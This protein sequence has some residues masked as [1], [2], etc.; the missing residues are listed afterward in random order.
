MYK[1]SF[2]DGRQ[3]M[4]IA[5]PDKKT[6]PATGPQ[7]PGGEPAARVAVAGATGYAGQELVRLLARHPAV[8]LTAAMSSGATSAPRPLPALARIWDQAV[9]PLDLDQLSSSA[10]VVFLALPETASAEVAPQAARAGD[11]RHRPLRRLP[12]PRRGGPPALVP[13]HRDAAA[14]NRLRAPRARRRGHPRRAA[15]VVPRLLSYRRAA[16]A[17]AARRRS[18]HRGARHRRREV[19]HLRRRQGAERPHA[20]LREPRQRRRLRCLLAPAQRRDRAGAAARGDVRSPSRPTRPRH[21][22]D[23]LRLAEERD[24]RGAGGEGARGRLSRRGVRAADRRRA[25][26]DQ[27]RGPHQLLRYRLEGGRGAQPARADRG[28]R[29][30]GE[31]RGW[32]GGAEPQ[33]RSRP[34]RTDGPAVTR[35]TRRRV[36]K[37]P[38][39]TRQPQKDPADTRRA[40][41]RQDPAIV[42]KLGGELLEQPDDLARIATG[43]A[44]LAQRTSL[45]VVHGGG[46]EIDSALATAGIA[47]QQVDG[48]RVTDARTLDVVVAVLAGAI[49]TRLVAALR[50][51][52]AR[53]VGLTGADASVATMKRSQPIATVAGPKVDLGLVGSPINNGS[54]ELLTDLLARR[55]VPVVACIGATRDGELLNVNADTLAA[56]LASSLEARRLV[57]AGGTSG[58]L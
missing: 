24:D 26:G 48:L 13:V 41:R 49:N 12:H 32:P 44:A 5:A 38:G 40:R 50:K 7:A 2:A 31:G 15:R 51:A 3:R 46:R 39:D 25:T 19:G 33:H 57:I 56:H 4:P 47:K 10:D 1:Y 22:R 30:P 6:A 21:P 20:F 23:D 27:A 14:G 58:V 16:G 28:A 43:I 11:A 8:R 55:Y 52:G 18:A 54:P 53:P 42:L 17:R 45:V 37:D 34:R 35:T 36:Q 9:T 29:Q